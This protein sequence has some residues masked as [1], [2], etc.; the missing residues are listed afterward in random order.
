MSVKL[1]TEHHLEY[2]SLQ[3][4]CIGSSESTLVKMPH[5]LKSHAAAHRS[6]VTKSHKLTHLF[7]K[8]SQS[9]L[10]ESEDPEMPY[11]TNMVP[12][13][14]QDTSLKKRKVSVPSVPMRTPIS[15]PVI[16][17]E[18]NMSVISNSSISTSVNIKKVSEQLQRGNYFVC[19]SSGTIQNFGFWNFH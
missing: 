2:L 15:T 17:V 5:C 3:G 16:P 7:I 8:D 4:D 14:S 10:Q 9:Q 13:A 11:Q 12:P 18:K 6:Y 1:L 19:G